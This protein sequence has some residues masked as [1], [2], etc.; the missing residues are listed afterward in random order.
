MSFSEDLRYRP[1]IDG[2]SERSQA[3]CEGGDRS[4][5]STG[6]PPQRRKRLLL[7]ER[8]CVGNVLEDCGDFARK[9]QQHGHHHALLG[10]ASGYEG[11]EL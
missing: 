7:E 6:G 1:H 10:S 9:L 4:L 11:Q 5:G 8:Q 2:P 3:E